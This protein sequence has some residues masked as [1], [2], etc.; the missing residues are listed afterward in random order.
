MRMFSKILAGV[1]AVSTAAV[2]MAGPALADPPKTPR[3]QDIVGVGSDTIQY[4]FDQLSTNY[5]KTI[6]TSDAHFY[7]YDAT[8]TADITPK[9]GCSAIT[10]PDG[11]G[12]GKSALESSQAL[13]T[14]TKWCIDYSRSSSSRATGDPACSTASGSGICFIDIGGDAVT[15]AARSAAAGG[16]DA[17]ASLTAAQLKKIYLCQVTNWS[18][19]G[20]KSAPIEAFLPQSA[21][22][23][24]A[25]FL[26]AIGV[27]TPGSCVSDGA[28]TQDP[29][30]TIQENEGQDPSLDS[31]EAIFPYS[32]A[33]YIAQG[34]HDAACTSGCGGTVN[35]NPVCAPKAPENAFGCNETTTGAGQ[36]VILDLMK[37]ANTNPTTPYPLPAEPTP[38]KTNN[39]P[40]VSTH[41]NATFQRIVFAIVRA[42]ATPPA[43]PIP[44][45][46]QPIFNPASAS[47][48]GYVCS[49][50]GEKIIKDYGFLFLTSAPNACGDPLNGTG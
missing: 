14:G 47:S 48:P 5:N 35:D 43:N 30:G 36:P 37:I 40:K 22:G 15:W 3:A 39:T 17:P 42:A 33:D 26:A 10:R 2:M 24:R 21:S 49:A 23:T 25:F 18:K 32:V 8:G 16:T 13:T 9:T 6:T 46:L 41:F 20:G 29:G 50:A 38:P 1:A 31:P 28:T 45:Y 19:V 7:S 11:S 34:Y 4:L 44:S 27:T 12:A